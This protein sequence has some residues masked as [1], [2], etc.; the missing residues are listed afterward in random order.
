MGCRSCLSRPPPLLE[1]TFSR[2]HVPLRPL[3]VEHDAGGC[4]RRRDAKDWMKPGLRRVAATLAPETAIS[5]FRLPSFALFGTPYRAT[6]DYCSLACS[7]GS[8]SPGDDN[9]IIIPLGA[10][11]CCCRLVLGTRVGPARRV[12]VETERLLRDACANREPLAL[13]ACWK[14]SR[15]AVRPRDSCLFSLR[16]PSRL[17]FVVERLSAHLL[18]RDLGVPTLIH[19]KEPG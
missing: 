1:A 5:S 14:Q 10:K 18:S 19:M 16:G 3:D 2:A 15:R 7:T 4:S 6:H 17:S 12:C 8:A 13:A 9:A 11:R